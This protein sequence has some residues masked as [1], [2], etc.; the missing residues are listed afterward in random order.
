MRKDAAS[1]QFSG[2]MLIC[3]AQVR[4]EVAVVEEEEEVVVV[5]IT[6]VASRA[7]PWSSWT[8]AVMGRG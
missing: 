3:S 7:R 5:N 4:E 6:A 1:E 8:T 2:W